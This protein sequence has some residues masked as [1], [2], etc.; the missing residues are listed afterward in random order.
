MLMTIAIES[1]RP[2]EIAAL[3]RLSAD[4]AQSLYPPESNFLL[5][6][7]ELEQPGVRFYTARDDDGRALGIAALVAADDAATA[8]LKRM[9]VHPEARGQGIAGRLLDRIETDALA[10]GIREIVLE[11]GPDSAAALAFYRTAGYREIPRF[12]QYIGEEFSVCFAKALAE[13]SL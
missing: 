13:G 3:L 8:E 7:D 5:S 12:G 9:F 4:F 10:G 1:P 6:A 11:T 2:A